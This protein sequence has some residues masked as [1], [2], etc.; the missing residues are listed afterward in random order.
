[1]K[2]QGT[3]G[4]GPKKASTGMIEQLL[5][6]GQLLFDSRVP[7]TLKLLLPVAA[8]LYWLWPIDL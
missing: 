4:T 6:A 5:R 1:M 3:T 7:F 8:V 2:Q